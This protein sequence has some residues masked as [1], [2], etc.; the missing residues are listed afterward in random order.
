MK[1]FKNIRITIIQWI[2]EKSIGFYARNFKKNKPVWNLTKE[3]LVCYSNHTLGK[4]MFLFLNRN[5]LEIIPK[6]EHHD[7]YHVLTNYQANTID[8][9]ALQ[10]LCFGNG[11]RTINLFLIIIVGTLFIPENLSFYIQSYRIG[12][13]ANR[14]YDLDFKK[15]LKVNL[16]DLQSVIFSEKQVFNL[17]NNNTLNKSHAITF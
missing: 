3:D 7:C 11:K 14:F 4:E 6:S 16:K 13:Q 10:Y 9:I 15:L 12:K 2:F 1:K 8:E 17:Y 5:N